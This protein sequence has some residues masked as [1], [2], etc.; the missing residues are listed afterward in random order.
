MFA[1]DLD[2]PDG[3]LVLEVV[4]EELGGDVVLEDL[5]LEHAEVGFLHRELGQ[6]DRVLETGDGH[7]PNDSIDGLL[8]EFAERS[9]RCLSA[10]YESIK[11]RRPLV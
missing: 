6:L 8:I 2:H 10:V 7:R 1:V 5:V 11:S 3:L 4:V 9:C